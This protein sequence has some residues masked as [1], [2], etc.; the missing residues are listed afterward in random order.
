VNF[1]AFDPNEGGK[2]E[3]ISWSWIGSSI[4]E[5]DEFCPGIRSRGNS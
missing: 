2:N 5:R 1:I 4:S 3:E